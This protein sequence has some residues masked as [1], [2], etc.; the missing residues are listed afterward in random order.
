M[1]DA[2]NKVPVK[3]AG[4]AAPAARSWSP[5]ENLRQEIDRLFDDFHPLG[6]RSPFGRMAGGEVP[7]PKLGALQ[8]APAVD[9]VE[10]D[11]EFEIT[12]EL[13]GMDEKDIELKLAGDML[14]IKGEKTEQKEEREKDYYLSERRYGSFQRSF[15]LPDGI[16]TGKID[17]SFAKGVLT[18]KMPKS[19]EAQKK[20]KKIEVK[21]A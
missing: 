8:I 20:E 5:F 11:N 18:V 21:P 4:K 6:W 9:L 3:S 10:K 13:P 17:A 15:Q 2:S 1:A 16:D 7:W 12:C 19:A 14:T